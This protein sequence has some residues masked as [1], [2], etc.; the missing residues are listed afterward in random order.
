M[1]VTCPK[2]RATLSISD[3]RLP[4]GK[5]FN[6]ACPRCGT[7][8]AIDTSRASALPTTAAAPETPVEP[9]AEP[10]SYGERGQPQALVCIHE[11]AEQ[12]KVLTSLKEAG[13]AAHVAANPA[14]AL[15]RLRFAAYAVVVVR[16]GFDDV[17]GSASS[18]S[19]TLAETPMVT[20]RNTHMV[21]V[22]PS[23]ASHDSRAAFAK[24]VDLTIHPSDLPHFSD[25]LKRSLAETEQMYRVFRET[26][27]A[28]GRG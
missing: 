16:E 3:D 4:K 5:V 27:Q 28:L 19:E 12:Q 1:T 2:C 26:H 13:Y 10:I 24:S 8:I 18:L 20:R 17:A 14:D 15:E 21:F 11:S 25:A 22:G 7:V 9:P 23:V 6:A